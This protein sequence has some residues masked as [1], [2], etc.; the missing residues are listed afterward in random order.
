VKIVSQGI[1]YEPKPR[2]SSWRH[3]TDAYGYWNYRGGVIVCG[4][5][6]H[7]WKWVRERLFLDGT[8]PEG[9]WD[10]QCVRCLRKERS[11]VKRPEREV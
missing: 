9:P 10:L 5:R 2:Y 11:P 1:I 6:G 7:R 4:V 3:L 8:E